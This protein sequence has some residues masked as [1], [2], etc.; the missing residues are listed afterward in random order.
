MKKIMLCLLLFLLVVVLFLSLYEHSYAF[1]FSAGEKLKEKQEKFGKNLTK[2]FFLEAKW[3]LLLKMWQETDMALS[4]SP[5]HF[6][7]ILLGE[8]D[9]KDGKDA[10]RERMPQPLRR[11]LISS[12]TASISDFEF[13]HVGFTSEFEL[14]P[15]IIQTEFLAPSLYFRWK[16]FKIIGVKTKVELDGDFSSWEDFPIK[17]IIFSQFKAG[18]ARFQPGY[19]IFRNE[20]GFKASY[21]DQDEEIFLKLNFKTPV[22]DFKQAKVSFDGTVK[23]FSAKGWK[24]YAGPA[25]VVQNWDLKQSAGML[26]IYG[27]H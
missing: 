20:L 2:Q 9:K 14:D 26:M 13:E 1:D 16:S 11:M 10:D 24:I 23:F 7:G 21:T 5:P 8:K 27:F 15:A 12:L 22:G 18:K 4:N 17:P 6:A 25:L 19:D 3:F